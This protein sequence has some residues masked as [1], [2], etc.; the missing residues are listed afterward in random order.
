MLM[1]IRS[2]TAAGAASPQ[3]GIRRPKIPTGEDPKRRNPHRWGSAKTPSAAMMRREDGTN[4]MLEKVSAAYAA[5]PLRG[6][7][8]V[9]ALFPDLRGPGPRSLRHPV[10]GEIHG[11]AA[12]DHWWS[13][14]RRRC[15]LVVIRDV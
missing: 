11:Q 3:V 5:L 2:T 10:D 15:S 1:F 9:P 7:R 14:N 13:L 8:F 4:L 6:N 12:D